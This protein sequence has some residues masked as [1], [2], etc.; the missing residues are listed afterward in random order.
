M[1]YVLRE[2]LVSFCRSVPPE[3]FRPFCLFIL[4]KDQKNLNIY[5][6]QMSRFPKAHIPNIPKTWRAS[7]EEP[8]A[9]SCRISSHLWVLKVRLMGDLKEKSCEFTCWRSWSNLSCDLLCHADTFI[10]SSSADT[11]TCREYRSQ[12]WR[13]P[14][15]L[16]SLN[17]DYPKCIRVWFWNQLLKIASCTWLRHCGKRR[18]KLE[19][20]G[21]HTPHK[22]GVFLF[23]FS[24]F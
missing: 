7:R 14:L 24:F 18:Y 5:P 13:A 6:E 2:F 8:S 17:K 22:W 20:W 15:K 10:R 1:F 19:C 23:N 9:A 3:F 21:A 12:D 11:V 4:R 16:Q